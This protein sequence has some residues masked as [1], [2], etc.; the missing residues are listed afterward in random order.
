MTVG[1]SG[2]WDQATREEGLADKLR[3]AGHEVIF[4][5]ARLKRWFAACTS[6]VNHVGSFLR[7]CRHRF[8]CADVGLYQGGGAPLG[9]SN[10]IRNCRNHGGLSVRLSDV[11]VASAGTVLRC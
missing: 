2:C 8:L 1:R 5:E 4:T 9:G 3:I 10:G 11:R 7:R 6:E